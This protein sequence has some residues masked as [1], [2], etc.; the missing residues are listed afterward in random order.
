MKRSASKHVCPRVS[1]PGLVLGMAMGLL[2]NVPA[3]AQEN[4]DVQDG[5]AVSLELTV[6]RKSDN[7]V[8]FTNVDQEPVTYVHGQRQ[9]IPGLESALK[10]MKPGESKSVD[11]SADQAYGPYDEQKKITVQRDKLPDNV[12]VGN[13]VQSSDGHMAT[14]KEITEKEAVLDFNH[15]MAGEDLLINVKVLKVQKK[16]AQATHP[17]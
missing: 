17:E 7:S 12:E 14:V 6:K 9:L 8:A 1:K 13:T 16:P 2:V 11:L 15:P 3:L 4:L 5:R 10:G